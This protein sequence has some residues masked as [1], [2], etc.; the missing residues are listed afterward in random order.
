MIRFRPRL[1]IAGL[2]VVALLIA[3]TSGLVAANLVRPAPGPFTGCL[4]SKS[5]LS[6]L[7]IKG[8]I[9]NVAASATTP[10]APCATGDALV[11]FSNAQGAT[12]PA[13]PA[14]ATGATGASVIAVAIDPA[15]PPNPN[16]LTGYEV[17]QLPPGP[18]NTPPT[19]LGFV[20]DGRDGT[21][22]ATGDTGPQGPVGPPGAPAAGALTN[23]T[24][25]DGLGCLKGT[26]PGTVQTS[27]DEATGEVSILCIPTPPTGGGGATTNTLIIGDLQVG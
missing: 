26:A 11:T 3:G 6:P 7:S 25:L 13:G 5:A 12:G 10:L 14:G 22:G 21:P 24:D 8:M 1:R 4:A 9:Y 2:G 17:L 27:V 16:C 23:I 18:P 15:K 19:S 20:C